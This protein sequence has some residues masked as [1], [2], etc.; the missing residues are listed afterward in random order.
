MLKAYSC[1]NGYQG[2]HPGDGCLLVFAETRNKAR[3][4]ASFD[5]A[6]GEYEFT[7]ARRA[8]GYDRFAGDEPNMVLT[9]D[10]LPDGVE[11]YLEY[12]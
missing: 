7:Y 10:E 6:D 11:F 2:G 1:F 12:P 9:N 3:F 4:M 8:A 5:I